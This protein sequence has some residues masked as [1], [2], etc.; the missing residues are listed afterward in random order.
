MIIV[1]ALEMIKIGMLKF[2]LHLGPIDFA[3]HDELVCTGALV[4][5]LSKYDNSD[6]PW[7][8]KTGHFKILLCIAPKVFE[9]KSWNLLQ[10]FTL[11]SCCVP[12]VL[13]AAHLSITTL[14]TL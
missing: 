1:T 5:S 14:M 4:S 9:M 10:M 13:F 12:G 7:N 8:S 2:V 3:I 6:S 11:M